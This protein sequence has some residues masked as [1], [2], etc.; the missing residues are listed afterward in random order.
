MNLEY[1]INEIKK[2]SLSMFRKNFF[3]IFHGSI[4]ARVE[5]NQ[6][7]IN[8][9]DAIFDGLSSKD[10]M[11]LYSKKDYRWNEASIDSD[12]HKKIY[13]NIS[14]A[15]YICYAM[16][17]YLTAYS[18]NHDFIE[19]K[20]YFGFMKFG[21]KISIYDPRQFEDWYERAPHEIYR[22]ML[23]N[24]SNVL[25]IK[26]YGVYVYERTAHDLAKCVALLENSSKLLH[27]SQNRSKSSEFY[28]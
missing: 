10:M 7:V 14:E 15:K 11:L 19:P 17:P 26:G 9:K 1:S 6:F 22:A 12:I 24:D 3:G 21:A 28:I 18:L 20:D 4:S 5:E 8:K 25:V 23:Q 16:P 27:I 2:I 13:Q